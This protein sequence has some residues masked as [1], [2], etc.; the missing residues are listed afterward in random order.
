MA[1]F[2]AAWSRARLR[3]RAY[4]RDF[5]NLF[6]CMAL[7]ALAPCAKGDD[8]P[9]K[10]VWIVP[11]SHTDFGYT[12]QP[13]VTRE[14]HIR[15]IDI[16]LD[17]AL[18]TSAY[19]DA[20]RFRWT[21][22]SQYSLDD[23]WKR[24]SER[25][26]SEFVAM[27]KAGQI[28]VSA[29]ALDNTPYLDHAGWEQ[30]THWI[31]DDVWHLVQPQT[32]VQDDVNG[33][34]RAGAMLLL[35]RGI[36]RLWTG[37]NNDLGGA[38]VPRP[39]AFWW[40]MPD[41][42]RM[43]VWV[44]IPYSEGYYYFHPSGWRRGPLPKAGDTLYRPPMPNELLPIDSASL[45]TQCSYLLTKLQ[46]QIAHGY[47]YPVFI[48]PFTN[49]WRIDNDPPY[50]S[51]TEF[52]AAWNRAGLTPRLRLA[53]ATEA[54]TKMEEL[55]G[56][57]APEYSGEFTDWWANGSMSSPP[58]MSASRVAKRYLQQAASPLF[59]P[60]QANAEKKITELQR[61]LVLFDEHS[62]GSGMSIALPYSLDS[63]GQ[64]VEKSLHAYGAMAQAQWLLGQRV[65]SAFGDKGAGLYVIN[66]T[67]GPWSGWIRFP[68]SALRSDYKSAADATT[69]TCSPVEFDSGMKPFT[70]P[71]KLDDVTPQNDSQ[72]FADNVPKQIARIWIQGLKGI[73]F[74]HLL[75]SEL[76]C[77]VPQQKTGGVEIQV[78]ENSWPT[79]LLWPG[80]PSSLILPGFGDFLSTEINGFAPRAKA[81]QL[82]DAGDAKQ[83]DQMRK[84]LLQTITA[85]AEGAATKEDTGETFVYTQSLK[86]PRLGW[87]V[88]RLEIWKSEPRIQLSF[89][90]YRKSSE[91]PEVFFISFPLPVG[92]AA[93]TVSNGG[94]PYKPYREQIPGTCKDY[95]AIDGWVD[96]ATTNGHWIWASRDA[97]L[98]A[99]GQA[100]ILAKTAVAPAQTN[101]VQA[102]V[103][104]NLWHTNFVDNAMGEMD[105]SFDL[106][107]HQK[108]DV[109]MN[110]SDIAGTL[111]S[112]PVLLLNPSGS[113]DPL[114]RKYIFEP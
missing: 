66:T 108:T 28:D 106:E 72:T 4:R 103:F 111:V 27:V 113:V 76:P 23:W 20:E 34:P 100:D 45:G 96:Y 75:L 40:K 47:R 44:G 15:Y 33:F 12:D 90:L 55:A 50:S 104:N 86:H 5:L 71:Q 82:W 9:I 105:F 30:M 95:F 21:I 65:R 25:R 46:Q 60:L 35:D 107:W 59:G 36:H 7:V 97:P 41:G 10:E 19:P 37:I 56:K 91:L 2:I 74:Q 114:Y 102:M 57:E 88:R 31:A 39:S 3:V 85:T 1:R 11:L 89:K 84:S 58:A 78:D 42:R 26:K 22:E 18:K 110:I 77:T 87:A 64:F 79:S 62:W 48:L 29:L 14:L 24:A 53:T 61:E 94:V 49:Q 52:V 6:L 99:F 17:A 70:N 93:P 32:G 63:Q 13:S 112:S 92:D 68:A 16:A 83:R 51:I 69:G 54:T 67:L 8:F 101:I 98:I 81:H 38:P 80:M 73:A 43:F 109:K